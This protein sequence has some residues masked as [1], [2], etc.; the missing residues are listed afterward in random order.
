LPT[1]EE[2]FVPTPKQ[3]ATMRGL[4]R[5]LGLSYIKETCDLT[6][7]TYSKRIGDLLDRKRKA[8]L[9]RQEVS[10]HG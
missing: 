8:Q 10:T 2:V 4:C 5:E 3:E 6:A 7:Q 1:Q 9:S